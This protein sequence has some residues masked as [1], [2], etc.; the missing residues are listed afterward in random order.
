[1]MG[2]AMSYELSE[3]PKFDMKYGSS[4]TS[5]A[6]YINKKFPIGGVRLTDAGAVIAGFVNEQVIPS[7]FEE[8]KKYMESNGVKFND[9]IEIT[10]QN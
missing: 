7:H 8:V 10:A 2:L 6:T 1:M 4:S 5:A 9:P 3:A